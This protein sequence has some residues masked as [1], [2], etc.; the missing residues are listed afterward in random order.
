MIIHC[1]NRL[2][3]KT[4]TEECDKCSPIFLTQQTVEHEIAGRVDGQQE[5]ED[6]AQ[7]SDQTTG[8]RLVVDGVEHGVYEDRGGRQL[9]Q[10]E[11]DH[12]R[13]Q[14]YGYARLLFGCRVH[15]GG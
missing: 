11:Q 3:F 2:T 14:H 7:T 1:C 4:R 6:I 10:E 12:H 15:F 8:I 5:V 9:A 13:Y